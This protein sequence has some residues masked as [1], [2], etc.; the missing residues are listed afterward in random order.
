VT[1]FDNLIVIKTIVINKA[2]VNTDIQ[3]YHVIRY[4]LLPI[5]QPNIY[6]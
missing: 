1:D 2:C 3:P 6:Y 5:E 4:F